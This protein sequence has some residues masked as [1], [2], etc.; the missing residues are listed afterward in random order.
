MQL[1]GVIATSESSCMSG[2][3][4]FSLSVSRNVVIQWAVG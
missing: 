1:I 2:F 3:G 4:L